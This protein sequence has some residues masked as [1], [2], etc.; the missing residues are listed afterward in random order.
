[1]GLEDKFDAAADKLKGKV[2]EAVG[3]ATNDRS[4]VVKGKMDQAKG[5]LKDT[6]ADLKAHAKDSAD[7]AARD[8]RRTGET[9]GDRLAP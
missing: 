2:E 9:G 5:G 8:R 7:E 3:R 6:V 1:M 4:K